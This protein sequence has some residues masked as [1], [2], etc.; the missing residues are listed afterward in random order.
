MIKTLF[1]SSFIVFFCK[2][3]SHL[4][5][6]AAQMFFILFLL[7]PSGCFMCE[8]KSTKNKSVYSLFF[9]GFL[10]NVLQM[11]D[12][13]LSA[14]NWFAF[15]DIFSYICLSIPHMTAPVSKI[16]KFNSN[17]PRFSHAGYKKC[18][19]ALQDS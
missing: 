7:Y 19:F 14:L 3:N 8:Y 12:V 9:E 11:W 10:R 2:E 4:C 15:L 16:I 6:S 5:G 1:F 13:V 18:L 17:V